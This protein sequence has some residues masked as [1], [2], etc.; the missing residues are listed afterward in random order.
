M[1]VL[2]S[3]EPFEREHAMNPYVPLMLESI[4]DEVEVLL[5]RWRTA[6]FGR[7]DVFHLQ[8]PE[9]LAARPPGWRVIRPLLIVLLIVRLHLL[10]VPIVQTKHNLRAH[11]GGTHLDRALTREWDRR[12]RVWIVLNERTPTPHG[13]ERVVIVHGHYRDWYPVDESVAAVPGSLLYFGLVRPYKGVEDLVRA[14]AAT[15]GAAGARLRLRVLGAPWGAEAESTAVAVREAAG[16]DQRVT[17]DLRFAETAELAAAVREASL[18]VLPYRELHNSG[19]LL[20]ALSLGRP[21]LVPASPATFDLQ[22]EFGEDWVRLYDG[23]ISA[24]VLQHALS[25][26]ALS[27]GDVGSIAGFPDMARRDWPLLGRQLAQVYRGACRHRT[28]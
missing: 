3:I 27:Q 24:E 10:R 22:N 4:P 16:G 14:F 18:V 9:H 28:R 15:R 19:S 6:L 2:H 13:V 7:Y 20:L 11:D 21:V 23:P 25:Q 8:W 5:F 17:L 26:H 1:R 12:T